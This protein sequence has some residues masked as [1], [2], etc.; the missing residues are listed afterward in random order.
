MKYMW[1]RT[2]ILHTPAMVQAVI[3]A[4]VQVSQSVITRIQ[5]RDDRPRREISGIS[6]TSTIT[7]VDYCTLVTIIFVDIS[8]MIVAANNTYEKQ[9]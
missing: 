8:N 1:P 3:Y 2:T 9:L 6:S 7:F 4:V 5:T